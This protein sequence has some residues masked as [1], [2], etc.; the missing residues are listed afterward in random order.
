MTKRIG[1]K[2]EVPQPAKKAPAAP[3]AR[4]MVV[5]S[6]SDKAKAKDSPKKTASK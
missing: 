6:D 1:D 4:K 5:L 2:E 3:H